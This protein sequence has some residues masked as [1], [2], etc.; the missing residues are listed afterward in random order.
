MT[1]FTHPAVA[2]YVGRI[3]TALADLPAA[4]VEEI[5]EDIGQHL[6]EVAGELGEEVSVEALIERLGTPEQYASELRAAA[7]YP[8]ATPVR[9]SRGG[10]FVA[11]LALWSYVLAVAVLS[12]TGLASTPRAGGSPFGTVVI[13]GPLLALALILVFA[14]GTRMAVTTD[15]PEYR[16]F[17]G[18]G[19][20]MV[21]VLS[22][23]AVAYLRS[24]RPSWW[25]VRIVVLVFA[26][27]LAMR[28]NI[29]DGYGLLPL[30]TLIVLV[31]F[32]PRGR[33]DRRWGWVI[34]PA[35]AFTIGL[36]IALL[37]VAFSI[38]G[39]G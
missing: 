23:R 14:G 28:P 31:W 13:F 7:G 8:P 1:T 39:H 10:R 35:N 38:N 19:R 11:R 15:L 17:S 22:A 34:T 36:G 4:E 3:Q 9:P 20:R 27:L 33:A 5:I 6:S 32:G 26:L 16:A 37:G 2:E 18:M 24:L 30:L 12:L 29:D 25:L 21:G